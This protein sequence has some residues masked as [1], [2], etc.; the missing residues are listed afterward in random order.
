[1]F[2]SEKGLGDFILLN[3]QVFQY[4]NLT[5]FFMIFCRIMLIET[6]NIYVVMS[7]HGLLFD[8]CMSSH[9]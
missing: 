1:M 2:F 9:S 3:L 6:D 7:C 4:D 5:L 8:V